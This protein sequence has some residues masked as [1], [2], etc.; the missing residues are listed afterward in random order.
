MQKKAIKID[1]ALMD[2]INASLKKAFN[3]YEQQ[4]PLITAQMEVKKAKTEYEN[5]LKL[6]ESALQ[7]VKELGMESMSKSFENKVSEAKS[8]ISLSTRLISLID[9]AITAV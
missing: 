2:D 4:S 8:G 1:L 5:A 3:L 9:K 6:A 7:K